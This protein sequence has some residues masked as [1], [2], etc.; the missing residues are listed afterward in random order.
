MQCYYIF[1]HINLLFSLIFTTFFA[2]YDAFSHFYYFA[3]A[4]IIQ[5]RTAA[6]QIETILQQYKKQ[7]GI[8]NAKRG[9][10]GSYKS[11]LP[12]QIYN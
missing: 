4:F 7:S 8:K 9:R 1:Y 3:L 6:P 5:K 12:R 11:Y 2:F 10:Y